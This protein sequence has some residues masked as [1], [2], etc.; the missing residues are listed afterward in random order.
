[1]TRLLFD[2]GET[3]FHFLL[4]SNSRYLIL[5]GNAKLWGCYPNCSSEFSASG[6]QS[7]Y[8]KQSV[9]NYFLLVVL[10]SPLVFSKVGSWGLRS[11][12]S[13]NVTQ[14]QSCGVRRMPNEEDPQPL[15]WLGRCAVRGSHKH[16]CAQPSHTFVLPRIH[17]QP[18]ACAKRPACA[19]T[20]VNSCT[21]TKHGSRQNGKQKK[22]GFPQA[23]PHA[24][25]RKGRQQQQ[26]YL[27]L[28]N[29][30]LS[31]CDKPSFS[32]YCISI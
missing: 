25:S 4:T 5:T 12:L 30:A 11:P 21:L 22:E 1:M 10:G 24:L 9:R 20:N 26:S 13:A 23:C 18:S 14:T 27:L 16:I 29:T 15:L 31:L 3:V 6:E 8:E 7:K 19:Q 2:A 32:A 17:T 28:N